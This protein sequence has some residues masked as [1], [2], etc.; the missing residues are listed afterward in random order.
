MVSY[1]KRLVKGEEMTCNIKQ[2]NLIL[3][4]IVKRLSIVED[5]IRE[6]KEALSLFEEPMELSVAVIQYIK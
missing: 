2:I 5:H 3:E 1:C 4:D 6:S